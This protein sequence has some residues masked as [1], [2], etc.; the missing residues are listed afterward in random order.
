MVRLICLGLLLIVACAVGNGQQPSTPSDETEVF[1]LQLV[2]A[3]AEQR[4][5][6]LADHPRLITVELRKALVRRGNALFVTEKYAPAFELYR[7]AEKVAQQI[8]DKEGLAETALNI[9]SVYYSQGKHDFAVESYRKAQ[10]LFTTLA[11]RSEAARSLFGLAL[12]YQAQQKLPEALESFK[13]ALSEFET[14]HDQNEI[15][16]TLAA[17]GGIQYAQGNYDAAAKTFLRAASLRENGESLVYI[18]EAFYRQHDYANALVH[19]QRSLAYF[20]Q[21]R[22]AAGMISALNGSANCYYYQ[23]N[24]EQALALYQR[25]LNISERLNDKSGIATQLQNIGNVHRA[26]GD[27]GSALQSYLSSLSVARETST[28]T[29]VANTLGSIGLVRSLQGD[30][31]QA[32]EYFEQS[33]KEFE[34]SGD[35]VG[36]ARMLS[37]I[38]NVQYLQGQYDLALGAY[39]KSLALYRSKDDKLNQAHILLG[40]G[41]VYI[42]KQKFAASLENYQQGLALYETLSRKADSADALTRMA[43]AYR[44]QGEYAKGLEVATRAVALVKDGESASI[45]STALTEL[46]RLQRG[47][48]RSTEALNTFTEAIK[49]QRSIDAEAAWA[50]AETENNAV[51]PYL[52]AMEILI[53]QNNAKAAFERA[54]V[55]KSQNLRQLIQRS[56]VRLSKELTA[57]EQQ[58]E[59]KLLGDLVSLR[60]QIQSAPANPTIS[61]LKE[62]FAAARTAYESFR[63]Q[64]YA[65]HP[66]LAVNRGELTPLDLEDVRQVLAADTAVV[67]YA[68]TESHVFLFVITTGDNAVSRKVS[69]KKAKAPL[70]VKAYPLTVKPAELAERNTRFLQLMV[71]RNQAATTTARELYDLL[72]RPAESQIAT[73]AKLIIVPDSTVWDVPFAALQSADNQN[74]MDQKVLSYAISVSALRE[75]RKRRRTVPAE[76]ST[77]LLALGNP[78]LTSAA[79]ERFETTYKGMRLPE[80]SGDIDELRTIYA[81]SRSHFYIGPAAKK[82]RAKSEASTHS[83]IHFATPVIMDQAVPFYSFILLTADPDAADDGMLKLWEVMN[84]NSRARMV[85]F[86]SATTARTSTRS[87]NAFIVMSWAWFVAGTPNVMLSRWSV[88]S[89]VVQEFAAEFHRNL[90]SRRSNAEALRESARKIKTSTYDWGAFMIIGAP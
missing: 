27:Y 61:P 63:K 4:E 85:V 43:V 7:L 73:K 84:L 52:G 56:N 29:N 44:L 68:V 16:N 79:M 49:V 23:R 47:L 88:D 90:R 58:E 9:G 22:N 75:M 8:G 10:E 82:E 26:R 50:G 40:I 30:N 46:G 34:T 86:P 60:T 17:I 32:I 36:M 20:E 28:K 33:L 5:E 15:A 57:A 83:L 3:T 89:L 51:L 69:A 54:E 13:Q 12:T 6:L 45:Y 80:F 81:R 67:E 70:L 31:G 87:A 77:T 72:L 18:A 48:N 35:E 71:S 25:S 1:A 66:R 14:L 39:E 64:L 65:K 62:R 38:G 76:R 11:N 21:Q 37:Y 19:Y 55:A 24:Y 74:L 53:D 41:T 42:N 78:M 2:N 59:T